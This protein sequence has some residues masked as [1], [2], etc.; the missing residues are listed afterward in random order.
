M[1][2]LSKNWKNV[3]VTSNQYNKYSAWTG[4]SMFSTTPASKKSFISYDE[5]NESGVQIVHQIHV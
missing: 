2:C 4:A 3:H 1:I 5:Y